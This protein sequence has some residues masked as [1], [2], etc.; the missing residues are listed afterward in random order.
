MDTL[1][2]DELETA[3]ILQGLRLRKQFALAMLSVL[4]Y[5]YA[6]TCKDEYRHIW[7]KPFNAVLGVYLFSRYLALTA[8][9]INTFLVVAGPLSQPVTS[10]RVCPIWFAFQVASTSSLLIALDV[11]LVLRIYALYLRSIRVGLFLGFLILLTLLTTIIVGPMTVFEIRYNSVCE[12]LH[13]HHTFMYLGAVGGVLHISL[14]ILTAAK[15]NLAKMGIPVAKLVARDGAWTLAFIFVLLAFLFPYSM[16][17]HK[18]KP[19]I[20]FMCPLTMISIATCRIIMNMRTLDFQ[21]EETREGPS[22]GIQ[23]A[24]D[25][26]MIYLEQLNVTDRSNVIT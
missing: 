13:M 17:S 12:A 16:A 7:R 25:V 22:A 14:A 5:E 6:V 15:W 9:V 24:G 18:A 21:Q 19:E 2:A 11:I 23:S 20:T 8:Q 4:L 26:D 3:S 10:D 1:Q